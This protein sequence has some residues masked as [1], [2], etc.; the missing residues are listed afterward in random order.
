MTFPDTLSVTELARETNAVIARLTKDRQLRFVVMRNNQAV[1][2]I[3]GLDARVDA[4]PAVGVLQPARPLRDEVFRKIDVIRAIAKANGARSIQLFGSAARGI[5]TADSD[6]DF[7]VELAPGRTLLDV[8]GLRT[9]LSQLF[10]RPVDVV[11]KDS[12]KPGLKSAVFR[13]AIAVI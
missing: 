6:L 12:L 11:T 4:S 9:A 13:D 8:V 5:E 7:L 10:D 2:T 1:A 3:S